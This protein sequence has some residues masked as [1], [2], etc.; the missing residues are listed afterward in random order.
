[1]PPKEIPGYYFDPVKK[2]Y[3]A[4][5]KGAPAS[6]AYSSSDVKRRRLHEEQ[7]TR[8][9]E[10]AKLRRLRIR[11]SK[12]LEHP[13]SGGFLSRE[14]G[15]TRDSIALDVFSHGLVQS[16]QIR[17]TDQFQTLQ[18]PLFT[19]EP[20]RDLGTS[21]VDLQIAQGNSTFGLRAD[22]DGLA[23]PRLD[24]P[25][26]TWVSE[27]WEAPTS[28]VTNRSSRRHAITWFSSFNENGIS[29]IPMEDTRPGQRTPSG[30]RDITMYS[31]A[32]ANDFS[33]LLFAFG[34]SDGILTMDKTRLDLKWI[35]P[36]VM[37]D[38]WALE[39]QND[40]NDVLLS[41]GRGGQL[42]CNDLRDSRTPT[43]SSTLIT[44][45]SSIT[46]IKQLDPNRI[47]VAGLESSLCQYDI[48]YL[49]L[50]T[51]R[52]VSR[53]RPPN[54]LTTRQTTAKASTR[55]ILQYPDYH[56]TATRNVGFDVD[57]EIGV[58]AAAQEFNGVQP[59]VRLFSL[60][61][62]HTLH[63]AALERH[64][65]SISNPYGD[66]VRCLKLCRD[67]DDRMKSLYIGLGSSIQRFAW[68]DE[69]ENG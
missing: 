61:G 22:V 23:H 2:K 16:T 48:R 33:P 51:G 18:N 7:S 67:I 35:K 17:G 50:D 52:V 69:A 63:S 29:I 62:G 68:A 12:L 56:N 27:N 25:E 46:H 39:F 10:T 57:L 41:G 9:E 58:I 11:R 21:T 28:I 64:Y 19:L 32:A 65:G 15:Q 37:R 36:I 43:E 20:R 4:V 42:Q 3:F 49:K 31:S 24:F 13:F 5:K 6:A 40:K 44:H 30:H 59:L 45:P 53:Q 8:E 47:L 26:T 38:V 55:T 34:S 1:M 66:H 60:W 14:Q 54:R